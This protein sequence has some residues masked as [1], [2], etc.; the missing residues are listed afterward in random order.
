MYFPEK[1]V[2]VDVLGFG[3]LSK[4]MCMSR[5]SGALHLTFRI[6]P[7]PRGSLTVTVTV[8]WGGHSAGVPNQSEHEN[9][10]SPDHRS[11]PLLTAADKQCYLLCMLLEVV[12]DSGNHST[13]HLVGRV[14]LGCT[15]KGSG[16]YQLCKLGS[17]RRRAAETVSDREGF[18]LGPTLGPLVIRYD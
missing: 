11:R 13:D 16:W 18:L 15:C 3:Y 1:D 7:M 12:S 10:V 2:D 4:A 9:K 8:T 17:Q 5:Q 6:A 14:R